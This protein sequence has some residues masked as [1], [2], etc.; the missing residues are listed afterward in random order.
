M[1]QRRRKSLRLPH[2][3]YSASGE[4]FVT[5]CTLGRVC[6]LGDIAGDEVCLSQ[7]GEL[8]SETLRS[9][10]L[11]YTGV[12]LEEWVVMPNH[13]HAV[14]RFQRPL[15]KDA[16]MVNGS[17]SL[18]FSATG[19][20]PKLGVL[21][22]GLKSASSRLIRE[23]IDPGFAWQRNYYEHVIRNEEGLIKVREYIRDNPRKWEEDRNHP[24]RMPVK[25]IPVQERL[26]NRSFL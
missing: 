8:I 6:C 16:R 7:M 1:D 21:I 4:Y 13:W 25:D 11:K 18:R 3:D 14:F 15:K 9:F 12:Q 5:V 22:R 24:S 17:S 20:V 26:N 10:P 2:Y 19:C 23:K